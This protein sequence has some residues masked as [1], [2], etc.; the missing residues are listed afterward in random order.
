MWTVVV[1][2]VLVLAAW[3]AWNNARSKEVLDV[4]YKTVFISGCDTGFGRGLAIRL[5]KLGMKVFAGCLTEEGATSLRSEATP[6]LRVIMFDITKDADIEKAAVTLSNSCT[7]GLWALVNNAGIGIGGEWDWMPMKSIR[8][9]LDVNLI[10]HI[11]TTKAL[12]PLLKKGK[13]RIVNLAS[14]AGVA[15]VPFMG[16]YCVS[17]FG[18]EAFT[19]SLRREMRKWGV[20][21]HVLEPSFTNTPILVTSRSA[22]KAAWDTVS[23]QLKEEYGPEYAEHV[24]APKV[25]PDINPIDS[26]LDALQ[27]AVVNK[28]PAPRYRLGAMTHIFGVISLL[29]TSLGDAVFRLVT[30]KRAAP[31]PAALSKKQV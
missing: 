17:K 21:V 27:A 3:I 26:V 6:E 18:M 25:I 9:V 29:P 16:A 7:Q 15:S 31:L 2:L 12:L 8:Q 4:R 13:G 23:D 19:D 10:G 14:A 30:A 22:T 24:R 11:V 20:S 28:Y 1:G 5:D